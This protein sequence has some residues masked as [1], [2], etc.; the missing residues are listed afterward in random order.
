MEKWE[1]EQSE[2]RILDADAKLKEIVSEIR[3]YIFDVFRAIHGEER[4]LYWE[5]GVTDNSI[6]ADAYKT[7]LDTKAEERL[8]LETYLEVVQMKKIV[9]NKRVIGHYS[10]RLQ[11]SGAWREGS[12]EKRQMDGKGQRTQTHP[13]SP[14]EGEKVQG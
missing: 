9:E 14:C 4:N 10:R 7:A 1:E 2:D 3:K 8:P 12:C 13:R 5:K 6:K 11:H